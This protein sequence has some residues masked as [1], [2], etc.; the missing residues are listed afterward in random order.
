MMAEAEKKEGQDNGTMQAALWSLFF[1]FLTSFPARLTP[2][3][4]Q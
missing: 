3:T 2:V 4:K 1:Q